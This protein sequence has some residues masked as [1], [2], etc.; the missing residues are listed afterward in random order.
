MKKIERDEVEIVESEKVLYQIHSIVCFEISK[1][2]L[3]VEKISSKRK[4]D[5]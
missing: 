5:S 4:K 2:P 3:F 1:N